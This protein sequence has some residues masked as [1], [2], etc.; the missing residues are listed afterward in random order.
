LIKNIPEAFINAAIRPFPND[1]GSKLKYLSMFEVWVLFA[2]LTYAL[3]N[4]RSISFKEKEIILG[5]ALFAIFLT[6]LIGWTTP[7]LGAIT[8]YRFPAQLAIVLIS[9][10]IL[11]PNAIKLWKKQ[12]S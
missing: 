5:L 2:F 6:L 12:S 10:I 1:P 7:V 3:Y 9:L 8:R 4:R 11:Q